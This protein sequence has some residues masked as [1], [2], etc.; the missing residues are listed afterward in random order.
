MSFNA[1]LPPVCMY[2]NIINSTP[3]AGSN[4]LYDCNISFT[5]QTY[6]GGGSEY[7]CTNVTVGMWLSNYPGGECWQIYDIIS[8]DTNTNSIVAYL[9]D[10]EYY[11]FSLDPDTGEHQPNDGAD[12]FIWQLSEDG[13]PNLFNTYSETV[14]AQYS[15]DIMGR[16]TARNYY[17]TFVQCIQYPNSF[18]IGD[19]VYIKSG[20]W[21]IV[22]EYTPSPIVLGTVTSVGKGDLGVSGTDLGH[23]TIRPNGKFIPNNYM[24]QVFTNSF[25]QLL[26][27]N[28]TGSL[29]TT[30]NSFGPVYQII[31]NAGDAILLPEGSSTSFTGTISSLGYRGECD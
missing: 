6:F 26:Y 10:V 11:N 17:K 1:P 15:Q 5:S 16:F 30:P 13:F 14:P 22:T 23:F 4:N 3:V 28:S 25:G 21:T 7:S 29:T 19:L 9:Q 12:G 27:I 8:V 20:N 2:I 24:P 18:S 31:S